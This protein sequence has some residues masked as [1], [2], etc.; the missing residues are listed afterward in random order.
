VHHS[1][2]L[3]D[4]FLAAGMSTEDLTEL[5]A[6]LTDPSFLATSSVFYTVQGRRS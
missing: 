1:E 5:R 2:R 4:R 6:M 3:R